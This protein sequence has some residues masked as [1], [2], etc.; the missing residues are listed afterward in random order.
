MQMINTFWQ[1]LQ[2]SWEQIKE[3]YKK[4]KVLRWFGACLMFV[5]YGIRFVQGEY[6][7][8]SELML[9]APEELL[10]SWY[11][12]RRFALI[13][14]RKLFGMLRL[15]PFM[16]NALLLLMFFLAG[17]TALFAIWYWNG[18][19]EKLHAGYGLFLLL[20][21][22]APCFVEQ[23]NF[24][25]QAFEIALIMAVC[26]GAA[27][28][29]GKWLYERKSVLWCIIGFGMMVWS[30]DTYQSFLAFYIGIVL[31]SYICEYSS[32]MNPCGWREGI[33]H[34]MFFVAGYVVS[35]LLAIWI[36]QIK[37]GNSGY[38]NG[39][40][41]WGVESVQECLEG[42]RVDYNRIYRGEWPTFFKSKAFL[43]S[44]AAAFVISFWR[45]RKKKSVICFG[46]AWFFLVLSPILTTLLTAMPQPVRS[47]FAFPAVFSFTVFFLYSE[48]R[49]F[50][51]KDNWKQVRR[52]TGAVVLVLGIVIG[53]KQSV[54]V[55]QLWETAHEVSLG[56]R[57][58]AQRIYD[59]IC[60]AADMEHMEDCRVVFVGS[61]AAE[62]PKNVVRGDVIGYSFF[63]WDASSPSALNYRVYG[64][65]RSL[66]LPMHFPEE[67][68]IQGLYEE[69]AE[70]AKER[71]SWPTADS[72]F[73]LRDGVV[74]VKLSDPE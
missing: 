68:E 6:F 52:L 61:R 50:C 38:V 16:E 34:V 62:V 55:G 29:M 59:R 54:T 35:Q 33:L 48:I 5:L 32:G 57:A 28:C 72:V 60:I 23:F 36:C 56:D 42:I 63:Q 3:F 44:A 20:F 15:M 74:V 51:F 12:H 11:G 17:F 8:D 13:F 69:A 70:A 66:G 49:M 27:F 71:T 67:G 30:F 46:I 4:T 47:Q 1:E 10:Q 53:W 45:L 24:T 58:L 2:E 73:K 41:R 25:L 40:M 64:Y 37:G 26:I 7:V 22:S 9:T 39:M 18:R 65:Y 43:S 21:F 19:N 31:I 14:T